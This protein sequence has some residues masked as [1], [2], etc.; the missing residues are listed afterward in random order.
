M[1]RVGS[2][3]GGW[4]V[5]VRGCVGAR[6]VGKAA[7]VLRQGEARY[8]LTMASGDQGTTQATRWVPLFLA[9][10]FARLLFLS[11]S[12]SRKLLPRGRESGPSRPRKSPI[13]DDGVIFCYLLLVIYEASRG[14]SVTALGLAC[15]PCPWFPLFALG[16]RR[17]S[18]S[19][20]VQVS[21]REGTRG[22]MGF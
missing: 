12:F 7:T 5:C 10:G 20:L 17:R 2:G 18:K 6:V 9:R 11:L 16:H 21:L 13:E 8:L 22:K 1:G 14:D 3:Q 15:F 19:S 4:G